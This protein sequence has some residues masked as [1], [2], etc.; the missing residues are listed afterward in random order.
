L[1]KPEALSTPQPPRIL[2][3]AEA[4]EARDGF[5]IAGR[6]HKAGYRAECYLGAQKEADFDWTVDIKDKPPKFILTEQ[7]KGQRVAAKTVDEL[8]A[9]LKG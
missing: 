6:L 5:D 3:R 9:L 4:E 2:I 1:I 8:L 7:A